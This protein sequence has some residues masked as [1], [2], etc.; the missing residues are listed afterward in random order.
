MTSLQAAICRQRQTHIHA[1]KLTNIQTNDVQG[2]G[3]TNLCLLRNKLDH[4]LDGCPICGPQEGRC[5]ALSLYH[6]GATES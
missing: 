1:Y 3:Q 2:A 5:S 6:P 4:R